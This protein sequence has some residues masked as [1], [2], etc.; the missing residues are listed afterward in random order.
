M[1]RFTKQTALAGRVCRPLLR[2]TVITVVVLGSAFA[3]SSVAFAT[4]LM[5]RDTSVGTNLPAQPVIQ[6]QKA[7]SY[8]ADQASRELS[9]QTSWGDNATLWSV[10]TSAGNVCTL[11]QWS[12]APETQPAFAPNGFGSCRTSSPQ[13]PNRFFYMTHWQ[14]TTGG[15]SMLIEGYVSPGT[16]L[17]SVGVRSAGGSQPFAVS[18][19]Y[20]IGELTGNTAEGVL[21]SS[22]GTYTIEGD[23]SAG[24]V[25]FS[26]ALHPQT[27]A[28]LQG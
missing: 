9:Y 8:Q 7:G 3:I 19:G 25:V 15:W 11:L 10:P 2:H 1:S 5:A 13:P 4:Q 24:N 27:P 21:P 26:Q 12:A 22:G 18:N 6:D 23:D 14:Q 17:A 20:F 28:Q 16:D